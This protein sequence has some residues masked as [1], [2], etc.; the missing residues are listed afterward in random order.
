MRDSRL[1]D[2]N[3]K[4]SLAKETRGRR[5]RMERVVGVNMTKVH[6]IKIA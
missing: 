6:Y 1:S 2:R 3:V 5:R 4:E